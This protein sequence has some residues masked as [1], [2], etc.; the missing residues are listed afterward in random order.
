[1]RRILVVVAALAAT[2]TLLTAAPA[3]AAFGVVVEVP[4]TTVYSPYGGPVSVR[5]TFAPDDPASVYTIRLRRPGS[6]TL[7]E[8]D[9]LVN[10]A[11]ETSPLAAPFTW[12]DVVVTTPTD[13][14]VDVR[15]QGGAVVTGETLTILPRLVSGLEASPS[16]FY[17][18]VQDGYRDV[19]RIGFDLAAETTATTV[20]V[21]ADD[22]Y[23]ECCGAEIRAEDLGALASGHHTWTWDGRR[24]DESFAPKGRYFVRIGAT[25]TA[26]VDATS[27]PR[28]VEL[29]TGLIR[30]TATKEKPG[31]AYAKAGDEVETARGGSCRVD[32]DLEA[33]TADVLCANAAISVV[34]RWGLDTGERIERVSFVIDGGYY[35]CH[36]DRQATT[37]ESILRVSAPPTT[38]C[39]VSL[40]RIRYS[41][42]Y[43]A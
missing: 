23:G 20:H 1:M 9:V 14:V 26:T 17:P 21:F 29:T 34:W 5:F 6:G 31:S 4:A 3:S 33:K 36:A 39:S 32:R 7:K 16:P 11:V 13:Y 22:A 10:P 40:A 24:D 37:K 42:P 38:T 27:S 30:R 28:K 35:G 8:K 12:K 2:A 19:T 25:D 18:L 43:R 41:Y 15:P